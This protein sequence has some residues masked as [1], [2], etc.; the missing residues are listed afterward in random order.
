MNTTGPDRFVLPTGSAEPA[1][2]AITEILETLLADWRGYQLPAVA[3]VPAVATLRAADVDAR[4]AA[5]CAVGERVRALAESSLEVDEQRLFAYL[6]ADVL[7]TLVRD[8]SELDG[9][10]CA[11]LLAD[12][13]DAGVGV[14][15][16]DVFDALLSAAQ[17]SR[18]LAG[19]VGD[20]L[21]RLQK[22]LGNATGKRA[23]AVRERL[24]AI[25][26]P[27]SGMVPPDSWATTLAEYLSTLDESGRIKWGE[28]LGAASAAKGS[29]PT[30]TWQETC[31]CGTQRARASRV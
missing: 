12:L 28:L 17:A 20:Q 26:Q 18:V 24:S 29:R 22:L 2:L 30:K 21:Q 5:L 25:L 31:Q 10:T 6:L 23:A 4:K 3:A 19:D 14:E 16:L 8:E 9:G 15:R 11:A 1:H 27:T 7:V 13:F